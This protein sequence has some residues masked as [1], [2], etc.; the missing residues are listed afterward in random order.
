[1]PATPPFIKPS[2]I[3]PQWPA[4]ASV[5]A[6]STTRRDGRSAAPYASFNLA[7]H[8]GDS[9]S[10]VAANRQILASALPGGVELSWL[11]QVHGTAVIE[12][13][14]YE[15]YPVADAQWSRRPGAACAVLTAD[16]L[17]VLLC[18]TSGTV[19][20]AAHAGWRGLLAGVLEATVGAMNTGPDQ[21]LAWLGP[22]IGPA[23]FEVGPDVR[24][25]FL[26]MANPVAESA[27]AACFTPNPDRPDHYFADLYAL[28]RVRL[29]A[30]G[31]T[32][33]F[34]GDLCTY[35]DPERFYSYRRDGQ[36][37]RMASLILLR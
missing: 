17:P 33:V 19:V 3:E 31:V 11:T 16:C 5:L 27:I 9:E 22:A 26:A 20:A 8:V 36:T 24:E 25:G 34:G 1:L 35:G 10:A 30:L 13:G 7:H 29:G 6:L 23:A 18:S 2:F 37:G 15:E 28:A 12:A 14:Q 4:P 32:R 21:V